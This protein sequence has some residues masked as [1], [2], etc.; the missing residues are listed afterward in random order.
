MI[1]RLLGTYLQLNPECTGLSC[2]AEDVVI[3]QPEVSTDGSE[4]LL[5]LLPVT[6]KGCQA[7]RAPLNQSPA[8]SICVHIT[9]DLKQRA[10]SFSRFSKNLGKDEKCLPKAKSINQKIYKTAENLQ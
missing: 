1:V 5:V 8:T 7:N 9:E 2:Q 6:I 10:I 3:A 4:S